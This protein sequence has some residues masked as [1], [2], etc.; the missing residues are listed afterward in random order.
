MSR[1]IEAIDRL[2]DAG[3]RVNE[4]NLDAVLAESKGRTDYISAN[5]NGEID[6]DHIRICN[7]DCSSHCPENDGV[8]RYCHEM[9]FPEWNQ[10]FRD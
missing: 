3:H 9:I 1:E 4:H 5:E 10:S 8:C 7:S 6:F 2:I